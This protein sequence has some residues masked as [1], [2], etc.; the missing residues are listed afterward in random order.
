MIERVIYSKPTITSRIIYLYLLAEYNPTAC[1]PCSETDSE[2]DSETEPEPKPLQQLHR[3]H[4]RQI[5]T[6]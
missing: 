3:K 1:R 5:C 2:T 6:T 4:K